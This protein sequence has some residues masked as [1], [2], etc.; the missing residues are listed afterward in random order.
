M[1]IC[2]I[3]VVKLRGFLDSVAAILSPLLAAGILFL[4]GRHAGWA[5]SG[6]DLRKAHRLN[7][8]WRGTGRH[9]RRCLQ[10]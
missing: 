1:G 4:R 10:Q 3:E 7:G 6:G 5:K 8:G 9:S 2:G